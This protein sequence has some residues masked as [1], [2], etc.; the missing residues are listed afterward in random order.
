[1]HWLLHPLDP[2]DWRLGETPSQSGQHQE[3]KSFL[4]LQ[5]IEAQFLVTVCNLIA[6]QLSYPS[7]YCCAKLQNAKSATINCV[8]THITE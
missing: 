1:M 6:N 4:P 5:R 7:S 8:E 2:M 3:K